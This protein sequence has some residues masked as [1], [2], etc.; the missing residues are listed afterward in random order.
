MAYKSYSRDPRWIRT[1]YPAKCAS[2]KGDIRRGENAYYYPSTRS[3]YCSKD[4]CGGQ[5]HRDFEA[6]AFDEAAYQQGH[7]V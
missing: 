5:C 2:C 7:G 6:A 3:L 4:T 1:K